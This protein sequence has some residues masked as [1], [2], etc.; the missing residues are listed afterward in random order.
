MTS[1]EEQIL[2][3][4]IVGT[5]GLKGGLKVQVT[6]D[7]HELLSPGSIVY[8]DGERA[9]VTDLQWHKTQARI[10]LEGI[11]KIEAAQPLIGK[12]I[13]V[14]ESALPELEEGVYLV[15]HLIGLEVFDESGRLLG[16]LDE[17]YPRPAQDVYRVGRMLIPAAKEFVLSIDMNSRRMIVRILPGME[18]LA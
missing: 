14:P 16:T 5:F 7:F 4:P 15:K 18:D 13:T 1:Q 2:V 3:G 8:L 12:K 17:V 11:K 6:T 10:W 9:V